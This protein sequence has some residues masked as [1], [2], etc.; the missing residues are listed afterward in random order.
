MT[1]SVTVFADR[2]QWITPSNVYGTT[3]EFT[4]FVKNNVFS[5]VGL[6]DEKFGPGTFYGAEE[7]ADFVLRALYLKRRAFFDPTL[8]FHHAQK[9]GRYDAAEFARAFGYGRGFGR[10]SVKHLCHH[11]QPGMGWRFLYFQCRTLVG[12]VLFAFRLNF[13]RSRYYLNCFMGRIAGALGSVPE[14]CGR[15]TARQA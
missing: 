12:M 5:E 13:P 14:F 4:M 6:F 10:L 11:R 7:G 15:N 8:I 9:V 2:A 1:N 3:V